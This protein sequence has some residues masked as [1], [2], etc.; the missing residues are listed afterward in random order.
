VLRRCNVLRDDNGDYI[1]A[2]TSWFVGLPQPP[3]EN[4]LA[5]QHEF[6][7]SVNRT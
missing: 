4:N 1:V 3:E 7:G 5:R 2:K 6:S